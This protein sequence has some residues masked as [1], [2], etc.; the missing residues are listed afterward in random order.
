MTIEVVGSARPES[1]LPAHP[2]AGHT[3]FTASWTAKLTRTGQIHTWQ[4]GD[5]G[6]SSARRGGAPMAISARPAWDERVPLW[7]RRIPQWQSSRSAPLTS[8]HLSRRQQ[9]AAGDGTNPFARSLRERVGTVSEVSYGSHGRGSP[10]TT[11]DWTL[12]FSPG[13]NDMLVRRPWP[14]YE[15]ETAAA[16]G[17]R[18]TGHNVG[19]LYEHKPPEPELLTS[20]SAMSF[21]S[22]ASDK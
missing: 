6:A 4:R 10:T 20:P 17:R 3:P 8:A 21:R 7:E 11:R 14:E 13:R 19:R 5:L 16:V 15:P 2:T 22:L 1:P 12:L 9:I 18:W